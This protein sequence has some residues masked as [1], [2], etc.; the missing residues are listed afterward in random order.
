MTQNTALQ[1]ANF[2][3]ST[4]P[5]DGQSFDQ[6][7]ADA[8]SRWP[9]LSEQQIQW[10]ISRAAEINHQEAAQLF[11]EAETMEKL[12]LMTNDFGHA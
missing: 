1:L 8:L 5:A 12:A 4:Q 7:M 11:D 2:L 9:N 6:Y 10:A 3:A